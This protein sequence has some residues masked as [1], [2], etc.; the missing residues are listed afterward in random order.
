MINWREAA[1]LTRK[2]FARKLNVSLTAVKN[3]ETGH[4]TPKLTKY[5]EIAKVLG[6]DV[7]EMGLDANLDLDKIGDRIKYAR[8]LRGMSIEA[9]S[10]E[11]GFAIQTVKSWE[12]HT[13][14]VSEASLD[15]IS[16][17]LNIPYSFFDLTK[18]PY[19]ELTKAS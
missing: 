8:L 18:N 15:R 14:D 11:F 1:N 13:A 9:F 2:E 12:S 3:W 19:Q 10:Y 7:R 16:R 6:I 4:S 5:S 17:A